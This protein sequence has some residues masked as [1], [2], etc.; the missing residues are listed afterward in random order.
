MTGFGRSEG[1]HKAYA[2][3]VEMRSVNH[4]YCDVVVRLPRLFSTLEEKIKKQVKGRFTRGRIE[5][6]V[7]ISGASD[8]ESRLNLDLETAES[9][10][11]LLESLKNQLSLSGEIDIAMVS[12]FRGVITLSEANEPLEA[13]T[14]MLDKT[15][16]HAMSALEKMR[17][18]EGKALSADLRARL[19]SLS[20]R[21]FV[22]KSKEKE[23]LATY[24]ERLTSRVAALSRGIEIDPLRLA[25]EVAIFAERSDISE[26][27]TRLAAHVDQF[28][29][30]LRKEGS[31]GRSLDFLVQEMHREVNTISSK[32]SDQDVSMQ[33]VEMKSELEKVR[34]QVQ[35][36]A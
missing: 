11:K 31:I 12:Q 7:A 33:V 5:V 23:I 25:Q 10:V 35:N 34:E 15:L 6:S 16:I 30:I 13:L 22:I 1:Q 17:K 32:S 8:S 27:R 3:T 20:K 9:Y 36:I 4:R 14:K 29:M 24:H 26:E 18:N 21:L 28:K 2:L 19:Q